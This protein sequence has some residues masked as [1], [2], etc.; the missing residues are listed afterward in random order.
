MRNRGSVDP[1]QPWVHKTDLTVYTEAGAAFFDGRDPYTVTNPRGW[2]YLYPPLFAML[3]APLDQLDTRNQVLVWFALN[4]LLGWG[5]LRELV[6]IAHSVLPNGTDSGLFGPVPTWL[7]VAAVSAALLPAL[8]CLQRG[9]VGVA[10]LY[11]LLLGFRVLVASRSV[12][13]PL[14]AGCVLAFPIALKITPVVPVAIVIGQ[15]WTSA[16]YAK[17]RAAWAG[18]GACSLGT[19]GGLAVCFLLLPAAL[20]GWQANLHHLGTWWN[21]VAVLAESTP[22]DEFAGDSTSVRN[23]SLVNATHRLGN[24]THYYF[25]GGPHDHGPG[26]LRRGGAGLLMDAPV[27]EGIL[28]VVRFLAGCLVVAVG[29]RMAKA[30]DKLGQAAAFGLACA[31]TLVIFPI[32][33]GHYYVL[34]LPAVT[35]VSLWHLEQRRMKWALALAIV[36]GVLVI[37]HYALVDVAGRIGLLGLGTTLWYMTAGAAMLWPRRLDASQ[38]SVSRVVT[39]AALAAERPMAA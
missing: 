24:W 1:N 35:F 15:Q 19:A 6:R 27:V 38:A 22:A 11:V 8:N 14:V 7:G 25:A 31:A 33:R 18:A 13:G 12:V 30:R 21:V 37:T 36:P 2:G 28:L 4:V 17:S 5:C 3:V 16:W 23:Q 29:F 20:V 26:Q 32:A 34:L 39:S 10:K 9:Q